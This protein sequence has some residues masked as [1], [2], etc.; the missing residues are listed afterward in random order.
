MSLDPKKVP[1]QLDWQEDAQ[2]KA[3]VLNSVQQV[4]QAV[5]GLA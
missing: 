1:I 3:Q 4:D 5:K 2:G